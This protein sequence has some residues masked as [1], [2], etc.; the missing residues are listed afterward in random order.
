MKPMGEEK[1]FLVGIF[2]NRS[3]PWMELLPGR[4][5]SE[6]RDGLQ[7]CAHVLDARGA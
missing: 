4:G 6:F 1:K 2:G 7:I 5:D 3:N